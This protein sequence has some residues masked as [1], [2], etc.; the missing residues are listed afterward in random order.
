MPLNATVLF[1]LPQREIASLIVSK[2]Q[3]SVSTSIVAGFATPEGMRLLMPGLSHQPK[4]LKEMVVGAGT[5][6]A[7][8][9][10]DSL[11]ALGVP[12]TNLFVHL[13]H[14]RQ[15]GAN[16]KHRFYRYHPMLHS[17][18]YYTEQAEGNACAI[19]GSHNITGFALGGLNGEAA[20]LLEGS[21][22]SPEFEK[23]R[24]HIEKAKQESVNYASHMKTA[25]SW[26]T[27]QF[28]EGLSA[29]AMDLPREGD[30]KRT[31]IIISAVAGGKLPDVGDVIYFELPSALGTIQ[32]LK[33]EVH[34][35]LFD[36]LPPTPAVGLASLHL[37]RKALW[38]QPQGLE[39]GGGGVELQ[40]D[41]QI[42]DQKN[43]LLAPVTPPFRPKRSG[44]TQQVR[45][46]ASY[47]LKGKFEY[48]FAEP[49]SR[50]SPELDRNVVL[51]PEDAHVRIFQGKYHQVNPES[52]EWYLV[53]GLYQESG[54]K[55]EYQ[56][57]LAGL[58]P[59][60][61]SYLMISQRRR[62]ISEGSKS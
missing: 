45:V 9:A 48:I 39:L 34:I 4:N 58:S 49:Q 57:A 32:H 17:K 47:L 55:T 12:H 56:E 53:K 33:A 2:L 3:T 26:W 31:L 15:T 44:D 22:D 42:I 62:E 30:A 54:P 5:Y 7:Y 52:Y 28:M 36:K 14:T 27:Y 6:Q 51:K 13:G 40:A 24:A 41:W 10:F 21:N 60:G 59:E 61:G 38:C 50:W 46:E 20:V 43:P 18:I 11:I 37:A 35:Y 19:V 1:D 8:E 23:V 16:A 25:Y 29:K